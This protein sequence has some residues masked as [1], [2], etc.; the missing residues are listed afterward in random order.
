MKQCSLNGVVGFVVLSLV[1][2]AGAAEPADANEQAEVSQEPPYVVAPMVVSNPAF[3][4]G[5][6]G[7]GIYFYRPDTTDEQSPTSAVSLIGLYSDTDSYF[8]GLFNQ[9]YLQ[10][11]RWRI[12]MGLLTGRINHDLDTPLLGNVEFETKI[13]L[14]LATVE[15]RVS[16]NVFVGVTGIY[17]Q[18]RYKAGNQNSQDYF[19]RYNM[20]DNSSGSFSIPVTYDTRDHVRYPYRGIYAQINPQVV[21]SWLGAEEPYEAI[22]AEFNYYRQLFNEQ[23]LAWRVFGKFTASDTPYEGLATLGQRSDLRG[24]VGGENV[25]NNLIS[26]QAE[27]RH[28]WNDRWGCAVFGGVALLYSG[29]LK[30]VSHDELYG[31]VGVGLR[32]MLHKENRQ[33][34]RVDFAWGENDDDGVYVSVGEA[35]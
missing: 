30:R 1:M 10:E 5:F 33:T 32:Y 3:G 9:M 27:Y 22:D 24:Y 16:Q 14:A 15:R 18:N 34:F 35:F 26:T 19:N 8:G 12:L 2:T 25:A 13:G 17:R 29:S 28:F 6:G 23:V 31:S 7:T 11:D 20:S 21:P 4:N